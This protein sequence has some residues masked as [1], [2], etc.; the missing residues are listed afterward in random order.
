MKLTK[1][2][3]AIASVLAV[4]AGSANAGQIDSSSA[5]LATEVIYSNAQ[6]V[7]AASKSYTFAGSVDARNNEQRLQLQWKLTGANLQWALGQIAGGD[8]NFGADGKALVT[9]PAAQTLLTVSGINAANAAIGWDGAAVGGL[10]GFTVQAFLQDSQTLVFN[11]TIPQAA[12]NIINNATFQV[13][14][15]DFAGAAVPANVGVTNVL[16]VAGATACVAPSTSTDIE[17]KHF[18]TH[19]GN[20]DL[21]TGTTP[22]SEHL[23][24]NASN[25]GRFMNFTQNLRFTFANGTQSGVDAA[26][27]RKT[28][29]R[30]AA[31]TLDLAPAVAAIAGGATSANVHRIA[32]GI[33]LTKVAAG[34]DLNYTTQYGILAGTDFAPG[35]FN[36]ATLGTT[37]AGV[38]ETLAAGGLTIQ[39]SSPV[40]AA[41]WSAGSKVVLL[42]SADTVIGAGFSAVPDADGVATITLTN[43][44]DIAAVTTGTGARL[45]Y[46]VSGA[47]EV[48]QNSQFAVTASLN[49]STVGAFREQNDTCKADLAGVGGGIK[50]D[51][52]NYASYAS[53]GA[54]GASTTVRLINN[55]E[56]QSA[57]VYGQIIYADG[58]YGPSGKLAVLK[59][60]EAQNLPNSVIEGLLTTAPAASN[61]F[62]AATVYTSKAGAAIVA[63]PKANA[64]NYNTSDRLRIVSNTGTTLRVQSYMVVGNSVID[65]SN[66]QG[67]DFEN[68]GDRVPVNAIDAQPVSQDAINGLSK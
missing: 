56:S 59:P 16:A 26:T 54:N 34:L 68:S 66:A 35:A 43:P 22:D 67:V 44:A 8:V 11:I 47:A 21:M 42:S 20:R 5:T 3:F 39:V 30:T 38:I 37:V 9:L 50:I 64:G 4:A 28:F 25:V 15:K 41:G 19:N 7:R 6:V 17:F 18:T 57:D 63:G 55:S 60:R 36:N 12:T 33:D 2:A 40:G 31:Q 53:N 23:R 13:N 61:P 10:T 51:V 29:L 49:K 45:Y 65:T 24:T 46:V 27:L 52:R 58:T 48:P 62:G 1:V 32:T 14:G